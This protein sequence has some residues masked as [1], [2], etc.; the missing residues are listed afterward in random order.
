MPIV[1]FS[2]QSVKGWMP[3]AKNV[4]KKEEITLPVVVVVLYCGYY[5]RWSK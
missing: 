2:R 5:D 1:R 4:K 3:G